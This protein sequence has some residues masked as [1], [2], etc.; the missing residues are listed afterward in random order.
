MLKIPLN[1]FLK[2]F[3]DF[4]VIKELFNLMKYILIKFANK[5]LQYIL[6]IFLYYEK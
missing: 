4:L 5:L 6:N 3:I 1:H 2:V